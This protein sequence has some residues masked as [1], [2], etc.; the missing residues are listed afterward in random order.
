VKRYVAESGSA[1]V[2]HRVR[3]GVTAVARIAYA[4]LAAALAR[5]NREG[6]L[7][8]SAFDSIL[9]RLDRDFSR[10]VVV[11]I[12]PPLIARVP[13]LVRRFPLRAYD[14]IQLAAALTLRS[15]TA[16]ALWA[17]DGELLSA[18]RSEG[19]KVVRV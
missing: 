2:R 5:R 3:N 11:E 19:L 16:L 18:A 12:R 14:A 4:E 1:E 9:G 17:A 10:L 8:M 13:D 15:R 7:A 6:S